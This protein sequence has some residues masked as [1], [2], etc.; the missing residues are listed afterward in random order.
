MV[1]GQRFWYIS[2]CSFVRSYPD[3]VSLSFS[4]PVVGESTFCSDEEGVFADRCLSSTF[5]VNFRR[6]ELISGES[7]Y[8]GLIS[9]G[10]RVT[11]DLKVVL[12]W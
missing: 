11:T 8:F 12:L 10:A 6:F 2:S 7:T 9:L 4:S 3:S 1:S 5:W